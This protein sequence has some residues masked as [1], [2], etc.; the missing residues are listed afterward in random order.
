VTPLRVVLV[1]PSGA[2]DD[3]ADE[4]REVE[5]AGA[6]VAVAATEHPGLALRLRARDAGVPLLSVLRHG[7]SAVIG[8]GGEVSA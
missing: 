6:R 4:W 1:E 5:P 3:T 2:I 8:I 7:A